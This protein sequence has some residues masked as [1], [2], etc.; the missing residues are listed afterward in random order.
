MDSIFQSMQKYMLLT[1]IASIVFTIVGLVF[2]YW[3][4]TKLFSKEI[5][6]YKK[7]L[8]KYLEED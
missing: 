6:L 2:M 1:S 7:T 4:F 8:D 5:K 3:L